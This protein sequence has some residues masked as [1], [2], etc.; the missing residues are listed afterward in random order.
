VSDAAQGPGWWL[1]SDGKWYPPEQATWDTAPQPGPAADAPGTAVGG[2][3][4]PLPGPA[5]GTPPYG[6]PVPDPGYPAGGGPVGGPPGPP[7]YPPPQGYGYGYPMAGYGYVPV[8]KTNGLAVASLV[9]SFFFWLWGLGSIL[10]IV[11]GFIARS[12]IKRSGGTQKGAGLALAGIIIGFGAL[13]LG[14]IIIGVLIAVVHHC[15]HTG[16]CTFTTT[17]G[18]GN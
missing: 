2:P 16:N 5:A 6:A 3:F 9:C 14:A 7:G 11:F 12:Q 8:D 10:A 17:P 18:S 1:A 13:A 4:V 15:D